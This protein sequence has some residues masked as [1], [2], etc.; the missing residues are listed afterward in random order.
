MTPR[1][2]SLVVVLTFAIA[3]TAC[4]TGDGTDLAEVATE[5]APTTVSPVVADGTDES[6]G[7]VTEP[8]P[9]PATT[10]DIDVSVETTDPEPLDT[11]VVDATGVPG[12]DADDAFCRAWSRFA[13]SFQVV[14]V[15]AAFGG[16]DE[17]R[18]ATLEVVAAPTVTS[19]Y[20][21]L[22]ATWPDDLASEADAALDEVY[23]PFARRLA[24]ARIELVAEG[25]DADDLA[26]IDDAWLLAL[27]GRRPD[28][29]EVVIDL[30]DDEW[31]LVDAAAPAY[32]DTV[33]PW[34]DDVTLI[35]TTEIPLTSAYLADNCPDQGVLAGQEVTDEG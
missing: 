24:E 5:S 17:L 6:A 8:D 11:V 34:A 10:A 14:A 9:G 7:T 13:G 26:A 22:S 33:G 3:V 29:P 2:R 21:E 31:V 32:L 28:D 25:A 35:T 4:S 30:T 20:A 15:N 27:A 1:S 23:G 16:S 19:A 12:L 18:L